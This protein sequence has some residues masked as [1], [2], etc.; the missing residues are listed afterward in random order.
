M[1]IKLFHFL[2]LFAYLNI[3]VY[4]AGTNTV[5]KYTMLDGG[6]LVEYFV[7]DLLD[8]PINEAEDLEIQNEDYRRFQTGSHLITATILF[9][10]FLPRR[11]LRTPVIAHPFYRTKSFCLPGYYSFLFRFKPF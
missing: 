5:N 2:G 3:I 9:C 11:I 7:D 10:F 1:F 8:L 6:S 4:E